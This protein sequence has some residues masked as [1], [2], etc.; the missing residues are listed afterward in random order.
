[1]SKKSN[2]TPGLAPTTQMQDYK[3]IHEAISTYFGG[4]N[5][6]SVN[7]LRKEVT[8]SGNLSIIFVLKKNGP[9]VVSK[10]AAN[11]DIIPLKNLIESIIGTSVEVKIN[12]HK[13]FFFIGRIDPP[14]KKKYIGNDQIEIIFL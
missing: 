6:S 14:I 11:E 9:N 8:S 4:I 2:V 7:M 1:M 5:A 10:L 13:Y 12:V 3:D